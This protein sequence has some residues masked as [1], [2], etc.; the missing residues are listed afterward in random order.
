MENN[1]RVAGMVILYNPDWAEVCGN[2]KSYLPYLRQLYV[3]NNTEQTDI[4]LPPELSV[5]PQIRY[6]NDGVNEGIAKRLNQGCDLAIDDGYGW[7]LTM[8]QDS[9]F[10]LGDLSHYYKAIESY[11]EKEKVAMFGVETDKTIV[12]EENAARVLYLITS[13]SIIN[14]TLYHSIGGFDE[15]LFIDEVDLDYC[16]N[17]IVHGYN[18]VK[19]G[20]IVL[21]HQLGKSEQKRSILTGKKTHRTFHSPERIYYIVRNNLYLRKKYGN[22]F[23]ELDKKR[24]ITT[25][26]RIKNRFLYKKGKF[27]LIA[28][29]IDA[30]NDFRRG[31]MGRKIT[32]Q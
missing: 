32:T 15:N 17:A 13:G 29:I 19:F 11:P 28:T 5:H 3:F 30:Y 27:H 25:F 9:E 26:H 1:L 12:N 18:I 31:Q 21:E 2:I 14:L 23:R 7:L 20:K 10:A 8:D 22:E 16:Y 24:M 6:F 4:P